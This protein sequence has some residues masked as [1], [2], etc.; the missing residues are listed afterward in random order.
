M[1]LISTENNELLPCVEIRA[2]LM[3]VG[4]RQKWQGVNNKNK[5]INKQR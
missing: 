5:Q 2:T 4:M 3:G 1:K